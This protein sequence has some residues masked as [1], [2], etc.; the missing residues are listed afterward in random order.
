M[1]D[2]TSNSPIRSRREPG[3]EFWVY[4]VPVLALSVPLAVWRRGVEV[5]TSDD[6]PRRPVLQEAWCRAKDVTT[7]I[8]SI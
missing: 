6:A 7:T 5:V 3:A 8:C 1:S 2:M 4:F